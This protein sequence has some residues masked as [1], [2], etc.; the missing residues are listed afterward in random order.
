MVVFKLSGIQKAFIN[1]F[2]TCN[3]FIFE[4]GLVYRKV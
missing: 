4:G 1:T 3:N 2:F